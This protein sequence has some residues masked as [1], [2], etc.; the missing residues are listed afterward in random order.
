LL[1]DFG[2]RADHCHVRYSNTLIEDAHE[3]L[4]IK[5]GNGRPRVVKKHFEL[6]S[7]HVVPAAG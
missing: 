4:F 6:I 1:A 2:N 7:R 3:N 5:P